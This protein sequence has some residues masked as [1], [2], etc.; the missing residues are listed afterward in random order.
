M[1]KT[2][3]LDIGEQGG[4][5]KSREKWSLQ[6][7]RPAI[8]GIASA[9]HNEVEIALP[10]HRSRVSSIVAKSSRAGRKTIQ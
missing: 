5:H 3:T 7:P 10:L 6:E 9:P 4:L 1:P 2:E 8:H